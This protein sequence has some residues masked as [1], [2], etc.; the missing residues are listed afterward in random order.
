MLHPHNALRKF[1]RGDIWSSVSLIKYV[2]N[3]MQVTENPPYQ[4]SM[5]L[6]EV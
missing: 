3:K 4:I 5:T 6:V 2:N 1:N